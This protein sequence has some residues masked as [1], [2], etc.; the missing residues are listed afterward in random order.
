VVAVDAALTTS[1]A[2]R[3]AL[4]AQSGLARAVRPIHTSVDGDVIFAI[5]TGRKPIAE[6]R[7]AFVTRLGSIAADCAARA[8]ARAVFEAKTIGAMKSYRDAHS[9]GFG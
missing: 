2:Q 1:E 6:P 8:L 4:M 3:I 5:A 9:N 7:A